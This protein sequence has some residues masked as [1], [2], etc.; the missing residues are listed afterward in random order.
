[1]Q[2]VSVSS[3]DQQGNGDSGYGAYPGQVIS[4][5]GRY[6][7]FSSAATN[8]VPGDHSL[9]TEV[10]VH[11]R[12]TGRTVLASVS[13]A[14]VIGGTGSAVNGPLCSG[15]DQPAI[16][17]NGRYVAFTSCYQDLDGHP[18]N[19]SGDVFVHDF[20]TGK[21]TRVDVSD[22][23][24]GLAN[25]GAA[26][27]AISANGRYVAFQSAS[28]N[29]VANPC[30]GDLVHHELCKII[31]GVTQIYV[32]DMSQGITRLVSVGLGGNAADGASF[33]PSISPD[34]SLV[35]YTSEA[36][37]LTTNDHSLCPTNATPSC[38][39]VYV[40]NLK[41]GAT[42]LVSVA[43][44]G[45]APP[46][47]G[48][49][50]VAGSGWNPSPQMI[51]AN[52]RYV[53]FSSWSTGLVPNDQN[54]WLYGDD[55]VYVRDLVEQRTER[56]S[57]TSTGSNIYPGNSEY[58][59]SDS[60]RYI[61]F[62]AA[63]ACGPS[64]LAGG[65]WIAVYDV[66]TGA[67][68]FI[69]RLNEYGQQNGCSYSSQSVYPDASGDGSLVTFS[70]N[71]ANLVPG[72]TNGK[73]D[74]FVRNWGPDLGVGGLVGSGQLTV[75]GAP[76]FATTG[77]L[78]A[79]S[80]TNDVNLALTDQGAKLIRASLVYRSQYNDL[81]ARLEVAQMPMFA[82]ASPA[83]LYGL[84]LTVGSTAYQVRVAKTALGASFGL[85]RAEVGGWTRV[86]PLRGG[87]GTTGE[88]VVFALPVADLGA[89]HGGR[90]ANLSAFAALGGYYAGT[91]DR[92]DQIALTGKQG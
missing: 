55:G 13:S 46:G 74:V 31:P 67:T 30:P 9:G 76:G 64:P 4:A 39:N 85:F 5:N 24:T 23:A 42:Q 77:L 28:T 14:G 49:E 66:L 79:A 7:A 45:Q 52:D 83:V 3:T 47:M 87:Y 26:D 81:F 56:V 68:T 54:P 59:I 18:T 44:D 12:F 43:L 36:D 78:T 16:S 51:S 29:L 69:D 32:R 60:G 19:P 62:N 61:L 57:V 75:A 41:T 86:A 71:A 65:D 89:Q 84:D 25:W 33:Y 88:E 15:A 48:D 17:A 37:N 63:S 40:T 1:M 10:Y 80:P 20:V 72:D 2:R 91:L 22:D 6:V 27:P 34:G 11:D 58:A 38:P 50:G 92:I 82:S 21:T 73:W 70:S 8:L 35:A 53:A 90:L